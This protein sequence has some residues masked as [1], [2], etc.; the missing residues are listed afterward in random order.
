[1]ASPRP[2]SGKILVFKYLKACLGRKEGI[3]FR[4]AKADQ[5]LV[6]RSQDSEQ[7][8]PVSEAPMKGVVGA[9]KGRPSLST[10]RS[11]QWPRVSRAALSRT[12]QA[13]QLLGLCVSTAGGTGSVPGQGTKI[14]QATGQPKKKKKPVLSN[15]SKI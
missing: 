12:S 9:R 11:A 5:G 2:A 15:R 10:Q 13:V 7:V 3:I 6:L 1:M 8:T 14:P 4:N